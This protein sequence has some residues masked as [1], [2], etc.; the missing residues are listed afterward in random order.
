MYP[1]FTTKAQG[2][3]PSH[4]KVNEPG[5]RYSPAPQLRALLG[6]NMAQEH[7]RLQN[8]AAVTHEKHAWPPPAYQPVIASNS[9]QE[10]G[11]QGE[12][13]ETGGVL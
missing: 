4:L 11:V 1:C 9:P 7:G 10:V 13:Y 2:G 6:L 12:F 8:R 5:S 3:C